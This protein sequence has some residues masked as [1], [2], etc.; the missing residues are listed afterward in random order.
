MGMRLDEGI[1]LDRYEQLAGRPLSAKRIAIL[2]DEGLVEPVGNSRLRA[3][4]SRPAGAQCAGCRSRPRRL[5][6]ETIHRELR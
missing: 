1:D 3:T 2:R 5:A 6:S 4:G